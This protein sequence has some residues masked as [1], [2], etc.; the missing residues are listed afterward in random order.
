MKG[1]DTCDLRTNQARDAGTDTASHRRGG[2]GFP[3]YNNQSDLIQ[4]IP[5]LI[6]AALTRMDLRG[7]EERLPENPIDSYE[8][9]APKAYLTAACY[10]AAAYLVMDS[11][12]FAYAALMNEFETYVRNLT[13]ARVRADFTPIRDAYAFHPFGGA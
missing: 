9:Y 8:C 12:A 6:N 7:T 2:D 3:A 10:Y 5:N 1:G 13:A 11:D 4:R